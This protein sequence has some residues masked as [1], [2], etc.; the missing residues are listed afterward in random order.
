MLTYVALMNWTDQGIRTENET[1]QRRDQAEA[2]AQKHGAR[3]AQ[4]AP[5]IERRCQGSSKN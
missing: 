5:T 2:L 1:V 4:V 3:I